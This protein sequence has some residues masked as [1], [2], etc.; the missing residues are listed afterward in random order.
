MGELELVG[1]HA[2]GEHLILQGPD[3]QRFRLRI[4][5]PLRAAVRRDRPQL[6]QLRA[7]RAGTPSPR[8]IQTRIR[9]GRSAQDVADS[10]GIGVE[11]VRRYE[12]PV[13]AERE[14]I[15]RQARTTRVGRETGAPVLGDLVT[16]RLAARGVDVDTI[17]WDSFREALG[18]WT[19]VVRFRAGD[20]PREALWTFDTQAR[21]VLALEDEA[22]WL[23]ET[24]LA[25]EPIPRRHLAAVRDSVFDIQADARPVLASVDNAT[26]EREPE[27][28]DPTSALLDDLRTKRGV[29]QQLD[30]PPE[31]DEGETF[32]GF[33]PAYTFNF[34]SAGEPPAAHPTQSGLS[35]PRLLEQETPVALEPD[36]P[37]PDER[38]APAAHAERPRVARK[39]RASVPS[40]DEIVFG[41][42]P[43]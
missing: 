30:E 7:E 37:H 18:P 39:G 29:R 41:A 24:E 5:E 38:D 10:A 36:E 12:G 35:G 3:G 17:E 23:S 42:K 21:S 22:R 14:H 26:P 32:E 31:D 27:P 33:G 2:D 4:D 16:D 40:W 15:A 19:V 34:N 11:Q 8:E 13:L 28:V 25:D 9:S 1:L 20:D 6:E 43:E